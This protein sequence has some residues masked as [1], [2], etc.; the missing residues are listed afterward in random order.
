MLKLVL[1]FIYLED[2]LILLRD[3]IF[4][5]VFEHFWGILEFE[6]LSSIFRD[7]KISNINESFWGIL[8]FGTLLNNSFPWTRAGPPV[9]RP[10]GPRAPHAEKKE[11]SQFCCFFFYYFSVFNISSSSDHCQPTEVHCQQMALTKSQSVSNNPKMST[12]YM[13]FAVSSSS[14]RL[15]P[16]VGWR[17]R[18]L[19]WSLLQARVQDG[20]APPVGSGPLQMIVIIIK[21]QII[22]LQSLV[23]SRIQRTVTRCH[24]HPIQSWKCLPKH[25]SKILNTVLH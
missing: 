10:A 22:I 25:K 21:Y 6:I 2:C 7:F 9:V 4:Q 24:Q 8:E 11:M 1:S 23:M 18:A 3:F 13:M 12:Y 17:G 5:N 16:P 14:S 20:A 19:S 15:R